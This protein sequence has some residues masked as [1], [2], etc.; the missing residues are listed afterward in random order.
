VE[1]PEVRAQITRIDLTP[2]WIDP[3]TYEATL[4]KVA[5]DGVKLREYLG[6]K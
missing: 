1:D 4:R 5:E 3:K 6:K 2:M